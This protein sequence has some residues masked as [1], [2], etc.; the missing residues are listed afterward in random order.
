MTG[1]RPGGWTPSKP[2][3][4][5]ELPAEHFFVKVGRRP[6]QHFHTRAEAEKSARVLAA[7]AC[8]VPAIVYQATPLAG[9]F[10]DPVNRTQEASTPRR[11]RAADELPD[12]A[13]IGDDI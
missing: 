10:D 5:A 1:R 12:D 2:R 13:D 7:Y 8:G 6:S 3:V 11:A 4:F 9:W